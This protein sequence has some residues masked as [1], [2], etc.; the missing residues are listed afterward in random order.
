MTATTTSQTALVDVLACPRCGKALVRAEGWRCTACDTTYPRV[1]DVPWLFAEPT[2]ALAEWRNRLG[3]T[4]R[5]LEADAARTAHA[6]KAAALHPLTRERLTRLAA[7]QARHVA[8]IAA[9][10]APLEIERTAPLAAHLAL[11]TRTAPSQGLT[12]YYANLH[13]DWC[14]GDA[15]NEVSCRLVADALPPLG[16]KRMLL[17]GSGGGRLAYDLH[18]RLAPELTVALDV[19]PLLTFVAQRIVHGARIALQEFPLAPRTLTDVAVER[20]LSAPSTVDDGFH[21]VLADAL[22]AP[23]ANDAFDAIVTPWFVDIVDEPIDVLARRI[24]RLLRRDGVWVVFGS[25]RFASADPAACFAPEEVAALIG[26]AGFD[27]G[28]LTDAE[29]PYMCS[30]ASRHG[31]RERVVTF[32]ARKTKRVPAPERHTALP[33]WIVQSHRPVPLLDAFRLQA[34]TTQVYGFIMSMIDGRRSLRDMALLMEQQRLMPQADAEA[35]LRDFL[36]KMYDESRA[37]NA[38]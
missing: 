11:R 29:I 28:P 21:C 33:D 37:Q 20:E 6:A 13:R 27:V 23:F 19:N 3:R 12:T 30:P 5:Q 16:G 14:W 38:V 8:E 32:A 24:N 25:M 2:A 4:L 26:A 18:T 35:A 15:E 10:M 31:R 7:A 9:L 1:G 17:L 22:R 34:A 36:I